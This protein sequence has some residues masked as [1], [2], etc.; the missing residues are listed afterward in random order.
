MDIAMQQ[1]FIKAMN[2]MIGIDA[3]IEAIR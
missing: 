2:K 1:D 3:T